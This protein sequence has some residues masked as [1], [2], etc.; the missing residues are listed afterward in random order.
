MSYNVFNNL[1]Q[2]KTILIVEDEDALCDMLEDELSVLGYRVC[3]ASNGVDGL[4][5]IEEINPDLIIC[6]RAMPAMTGSE[7][8][9]RLR[10][11]YPQHKDT[12]F[13]FLTA[14]IDQRDKKAVEELKP[15]AYLEKPLDFEE[16]RLTIEK[17]L[18]S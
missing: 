3:I 16:L 5:R 7:L 18:K 6:D 10:N 17:A 15:T 12:P 2:N 1:S 9:E 14:L 8:L 13:I 11:V 4:E